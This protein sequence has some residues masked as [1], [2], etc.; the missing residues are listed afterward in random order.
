M[1]SFQSRDVSTCLG[2]L[3]V[4]VDG[5]GPAILFWPSLLMS[6]QM[7]AAQ[8]EHFKDRFQVVLIDP[9]G[10]GDSEALQRTFTFEECARCI[11]Q[12]LD[13]LNITRAH[14]VGNSW[15]GM[16]GGTF[17]ALHP[18]RVGAAVLMNCTGSAAGLRQK[19]EYAVLVR[20]VRTLGGIPPWLSFLPLRAFAGPTTEHERPE[21]ILAIREAVARVNGRS[22]HWAIR[23]VVPK[24]PSQIDLFRTIRTPVLVLAGAEDRTFPVEETRAM[25]AAI[26]GA[27]FRVVTGVAH[28]A[29]LE[30]PRIV[31]EIIDDFLSRAQLPAG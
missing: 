4:T 7:W 5:A 24:R 8:A 29:G 12:I 28:L 19:I 13:A 22:V 25:A 31:D 16:I 21:V 9:P 30:C 17:V 3:R 10:H 15:G 1:T 6:A 14:F 26:P 27:E 2:R 20:L 18:D 23:S 11:E